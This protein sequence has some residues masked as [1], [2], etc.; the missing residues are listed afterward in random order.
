MGLKVS[1]WVALYVVFEDAVDRLRG[2]VDAG[3]SVLAGLA[4][5]GGVSVW[6]GLGYGMAVRTAKR[7]LAVGVGYGLV[8]DAV[9]GLKGERP[10]VWEVFGWK[11]R[12]LEEKT[13]K[14][15]VVA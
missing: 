11:G 15:E 8:Q 10:G 7:G 2:R 14:V 12:R 6:H 9:R 3:A 13:G 4:V 1:Q 5:A